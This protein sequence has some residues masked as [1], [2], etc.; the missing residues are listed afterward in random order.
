MELLVKVA[1]DR[2]DEVLDLLEK[3]DYVEVTK[4]EPELAL[5]SVSEQLTEFSA[6]KLKTKGWKF[7]RDEA[8]E[9]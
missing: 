9:R 8:N 3:L 4:Q 2:V 6:L 1:D 5:S 7:N